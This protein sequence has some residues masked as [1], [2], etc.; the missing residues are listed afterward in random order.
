MNLVASNP[1]LQAGIAFECRVAS[2]PVTN[3]RRIHLAFVTARCRQI[4]HSG[5]ETPCLEFKGSSLLIP[6]K[7]AFFHLE[8]AQPQVDYTFQHTPP[9]TLDFRPGN[10]CRAVGISHQTK[11]WLLQNESPQIHPRAVET[12]EPGFDLHFPRLK[13]GRLSSALFSAQN[14]PFRNC[15]SI[16][17]VD[18]QLLD[19]ELGTKALFYFRNGPLHNVT[20]RPARLHKP[21]QAGSKHASEREHNLVAALHLLLPNHLTLVDASV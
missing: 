16:P 13:K 5:L 6:L 21:P 4:V 1:E 19:R 9:R 8:S 3:R 15:P 17:D 10:I 11:L 14:H 20:V 7:I 2:L 18:A 12:R